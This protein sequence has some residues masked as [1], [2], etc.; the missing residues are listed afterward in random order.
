MALLLEARQCCPR[1][2]GQPTSCGDQS[3]EGCTFAS[4]TA[5]LLG[6]LGEGF[7]IWP[8]WGARGILRAGFDA[9]V[10]MSLFAMGGSPYRSSGRCCSHHQGSTDRVD[11]CSAALRKQRFMSS[12]K[13]CGAAE[14]QSNVEIGAQSALSDLAYKEA[15]PRAHV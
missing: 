7:A 1:S 2:L 11:Q 13:A 6:R 12:A 8:A 9:D 10:A 15:I 3:L 14:L 5:D 4:A